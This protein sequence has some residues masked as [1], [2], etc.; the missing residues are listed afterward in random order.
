[1]EEKKCLRS[2]SEKDEEM[3]TLSKVREQDIRQRKKRRNAGQ[4]RLVPED[5]VHISLSKPQGYTHTYTH[6]NT[7]SSLLRPVI[8][9]DH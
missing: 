8:S 1:M 3:E 6:K 5:A 2:V 9:S 7:H 4:G